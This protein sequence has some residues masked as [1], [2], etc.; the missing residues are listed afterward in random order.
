MSVHPTVCCGSWTQLIPL[1]FTPFIPHQELKVEGKSDEEIYADLRVMYTQASWSTLA[2][3]ADK[4]AEPAVAD[5]QA[6]ETAA[7]EAPPQ[8][9]LEA[10]PYAAAELAS[11][12]TPTPTPATALTP[13]AALVSDSTNTA[14]E[15]TAEVVAPVAPGSSTDT[16]TEKPSANV[17]VG[18]D[19]EGQTPEAYSK[20]VADLKAHTC[21]TVAVHTDV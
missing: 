20:P 17:S 9:S 8:T 3:S 18:I 16:C 14:H 7:Q 21:E 12:V 13:V 4:P 19:V 5:T 10:A 11:A 2:T 6:A 1:Y 15:S